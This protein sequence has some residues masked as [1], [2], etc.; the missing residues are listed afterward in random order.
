[1]SASAATRRSSDSTMAVRFSAQMSGQIPGCAGGDAGHVPEPPR[2]QPQQG[3][4]LLGAVGGE[5]HERGGGEVGHVGHHG[6]HLVVAVGLEGDDVGAHGRHQRRTRVNASGSVSTPGVSTHVAPSNSSASAP[7]T[8]SC[9]EPAMGWPPTNRGSPTAATTRPFTLPTSV[10]T[11]D[12]PA[13]AARASA[14]IDEH[15][16]AHER[17]VGLGVVADGVERPQLE[18]PRRPVAVEVA[19]GHVPAPGP[20]GQADGAADQ[21]GARRSRHGGAQIGLLR[22]QTGRS[23][24]SPTAPS[25]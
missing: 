25:R 19:S 14:A 11:P 23:S 7:S 9:S 2:R 1:M 24:F 12:P 20:Q 17:D 13:S 6:H 22:A 4:V 10:T 16:R 3:G 5:A 15:R 8:P 21:P 18:G